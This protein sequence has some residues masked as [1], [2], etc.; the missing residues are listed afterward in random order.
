MWIWR[1][2]EEEIVDIP[3]RVLW[4]LKDKGGDEY[5]SFVYWH[6]PI[7]KKQVLKIVLPYL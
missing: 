1:N 6:N 5:F 2:R 3:E 4:F 7:K